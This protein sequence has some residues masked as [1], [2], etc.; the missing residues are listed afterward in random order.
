M[1]EAPVPVNSPTPS[2]T[3]AVGGWPFDGDGWDAVPQLGYEP[4]R[5]T[6][7]GADG[8]LGDTIPDGWWFGVVDWFDGSSMGIDVVCAYIDTPPVNNSNRLRIMPVRPQAV[9]ELDPSSSCTQGDVSSYEARQLGSTPSWIHISSAEV[10][11][12]RYFCADEAGEAATVGGSPSGS[13]DTVPNAEQAVR[14]SFQ[15]GASSATTCVDTGRPT[16][17]LLAADDGQ[18]LDVYTTG[19]VVGVWGPSGQRLNGAY[20][21]EEYIVILDDGNGD[22]SVLIDPGSE[23]CPIAEFWIT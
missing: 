23:P 11:F 14:I 6:G 21:E 8:S 13:D 3:G 12:V 9:R 7:C 10:D 1:G 16:T 5:G 2:A 18:D 19:R 4:V 20:H 22:Y 15:P 17:Y